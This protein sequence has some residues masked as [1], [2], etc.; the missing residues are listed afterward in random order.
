MKIV[1]LNTYDGYGGAAHACQRLLR[2]LSE[3]GEDVCMLVREVSSDR[4]G[5][6]AVGS[7][8]G[9][10]LRALIDGLPLRRY[11]K[12][13]RHIFAPAWFPGRG[14]RKA[15]SLKPAVVHLHWVV[16][17]FVRIEDLSSLDCPVVWT[18]HDSWPFTGG[19][20]IPADCTRYEK[21]CGRCPVLGSENEDDWSQH[22]W[23][24]KQRS[25]DKMPLTIVAPSRW[26]A[27]Q[28]RSSSLFKHRTIVVIPN[29][30]DT[31]LYCPGDKADARRKL[32]LPEQ[33]K[34]V[35]FGAI[36]ALSD[37]NKG[38]DLLCSAICSVE[39][40]TWQDT[41]LLIFGEQIGEAL[42]DCSLRV[43]SLGIITDEERMVLL[44]RA[45]DLVV[46][47]SRQETLGYVIMEAM[48]CG[49]PCVAFAVGGIPELVTHGETGYL[50]QPYNIRD[51]ANGMI[52]LLKDDKSRAS[53]A[54]KSRI[55]I[56]ERLS[57]HHIAQLHRDLYRQLA[58]GTAID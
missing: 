31:D 40:A 3:A 41:E 27:E 43:R 34:L 37:M 25:W 1:L 13:K 33:V 56:Q 50:A 5:G 16:Q 48:S 10:F 11:P 21:S 58:S 28:A 47:P 14:I 32:G 55:E 54:A 35:L 7:R 49:T 9:G 30:I 57:L 36:H 44:Y 6:V 17:G 15:A 23:M 24:R 52:S 29:G 12:R 51:L 26:I 19:C 20:H 45:A 18:L 4:L 8:I 22:I 38:F 46:M 2:G 53:M 42:P 39:K